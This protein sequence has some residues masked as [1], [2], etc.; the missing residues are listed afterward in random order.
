MALRTVGVKLVADIAQYSTKMRQAGKDTRDLL[1]EMDKAARAGKLDQ[2]ADQAGLMGAGLLGAAAI[3]AKFA[4]DFEK[5]MSAVQA[6]TKASSAD[7]ERLRQAALQAGKDT[8]FSATEAAQGVEELAKAG[9]STTAILTGGLRGA[10]DLAAAGNLDVAEAAETAA[11]AVTQFKL[12]GADVPHVADLLAAAA[13][14]AQGSVHDMGMALNQ[15]GLVSAQT[16]LS[17]EETTGGLAAFAAAGLTGSDAGTSFK[18]MLLMLQ[19]PSGSTKDLMDE[20]GISLYDASGN[21]KGLAQFAGELR[22][23]MQSLTPEVRANAMATIFGSDAVRGASILYEQGAD[24]IQAWIDK[25]NDAGFASETAAMRTDNLAG[26]IERLKGSLETLAI[27]SASGPNSGVRVLVQTLDSLVGELSDLPPAVGSTLVVMA[28]LGGATTLLGAGWVR[29]RRANAEFRAELEATGPA[30]TRAARGLEVASKWAGRATVAFAALQVTG[31]IVSKTVGELNPQVDAM[32]QGLEEWGASGKLAGESARVLGTDMR[33]LSVGLKFIADTDNSRRKFARWGQDLLEGVVPGLD[34]T[35]TSLTRTRERVQAMDQA[36]AQLVSG[37]KTEAAQ[38][39]FDRLA[40]EAAKSK[41][42]VEELRKQFPAYAAAL[43]TTGKAAAEAVSPTSSLTGVTREYKTSADAAAAAATGQRDALVDLAAKMRAETDPVFGLLDAQQG[44]AKAQR[45]AAAAVKEHGRNSDE[46][47]EATRKLALAAIT[48]QGAAGE[49]S[50]TFD[51]RMTPALRSTL[52][53]AGLTKQEI[54]DV[55]RQFRDAKTAGEE[56]D[57]D[58]KANVSAPGADK[59]DRQLK[60]AKRKADAFDGGYK[61]AISVVGYPVAAD[62]LERLLTYQQALKKGKIPA[63]FQGP[64]QGRDYHSGGWTGPGSKYEPAG[65]VH[66]DEFVIKKESRQ[67]IEQHH[68]GLLDEMNATG[69]VGGYA[70]GGQVRMPYPTTVAMTRI[71][72][73]AEVASVVRP[74]FGPWPSSPSA[75]RGDSGVWRSIAAAIRGTGPMSGSFGNGYRPGDPLWHG[76][77]RAVDWM[78][79]N[80]DALATWLASWRPLELIHRTEHRDYAYTRGQNRGSFNESLMEAHRNHVH[81][82][83]HNGGLIEEP[84]LGVGLTS[85]NSYSFA[86]RGPERVVPGIGATAGGTVVQVIE[87]RHTIVLEGTGVLRGFQKEIRNG[88]GS[89][90]GRLGSR[91]G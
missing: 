9:V 5:Q 39:V 44:L 13:G 70:A 51:G 38:G 73:R 91:K 28:A 12:S 88:G 74:D 57:G 15:A 58:Y 89:V 90:Q 31:A 71:P 84:V 46:A 2:V 79:Y 76:S 26:D 81:I 7:M 18:Q 14:K 49:L 54:K 43:E 25:V 19:A 27:E 35:N 63:N 20:L 65:V 68:P 77:G 66:A 29:A 53:A 41:V 62:R 4:M 40:A 69:Q 6:A 10:L 86:E 48:L 64:V 16:G 24:G 45:E 17:I 37:G 1:G 83:M 30:G 36:L 87:H 52:L 72:S 55:E 3:S 75:Q 59:T 21:A 34:S 11:S 50:G 56:Y 85:G 80:Q 61:A 22:A 78:G 32:S 8:S 23:K 82:A 42:S 67:R 60:E 33:D 47:K